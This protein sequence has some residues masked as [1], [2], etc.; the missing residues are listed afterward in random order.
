MIRANRFARF[1]RIAREIRHWNGLRLC[2]V[3]RLLQRLLGFSKCALCGIL[4]RVATLGQLGPLVSYHACSG[5]RSPG[6]GT[7]GLVSSVLRYSEGSSWKTWI[8]T[9]PCCDLGKTKISWPHWHRYDSLQTIIANSSLCVIAC[10]SDMC[11]N[12][13]GSAGLCGVLRGSAGLSEVFGGSGPM[14]VTLG[15]CWIVTETAISWHE[16]LEV[17][18]AFVKRDLGLRSPW[19]RENGQTHRVLQGAA[20]RGAQFYLIWAV[21]RT[22]FSCSKMSLFYLNTCTPVKATPWSTAWQTVTA[23]TVT[24][25]RP[26]RA[27]W[28]LEGDHCLHPH[29]SLGGPI[30]TKARLLI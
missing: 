23:Q 4:L 16:C 9:K 19:C 26:V 5:L 21:L 1:A 28:T 6:S 18:W 14:L 20:Q 27:D 8:A 12:C 24:W 7:W 30:E 15:N 17:V 2:L 22:L 29:R 11:E 25:K 10:R 13:E 3:G